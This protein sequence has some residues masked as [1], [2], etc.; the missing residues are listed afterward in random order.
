MSDV[1]VVGG[2]LSGLAAAW[3][4]SRLGV[5]HTLIEVKARLGGSIFTETRGGFVMDG[6]HA[7]IEKY[8]AWDFLTELDLG[9]ALIRVGRYRDGR[10]VIFRGGTQTL[11]EALAARVSGDVLLRMAVSSLGMLPNGMI[12]VCLENGVMLTAKA[13]IAAVP[14]RYAEHLLRAITPEA[15]R[16]LDYRYDPVVRVSLGVRQDDVPEAWDE[17]VS[18]APVKFAE[19]FALPDRA[20][21]GHVLLRVG[22]RLEQGIAEALALVKARLAGV[23]PLVEWAHYW[24]EADPMTLYL[25]E[26]AADMDALE[27][28]LPPNLA[29]IG[30]DYRAR[31]FEQRVT[32]AR[33]AARRVAQ[34]VRR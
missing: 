9:S 1:I 34:V 31:R 11:I 10:L 29:L 18:G 24:A 25:P 19:G 23:S 30:S 3:E 14:A 13:V 32:L 5:A 7:L 21:T 26:H 12:G 27:A 2:G 22:V 17:M 4:L 15:A 28:S 20:P 16:L 8:G 33:S 6:A